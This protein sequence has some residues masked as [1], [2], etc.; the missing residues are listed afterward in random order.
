M[1]LSECHLEILLRQDLSNYDCYETFREIYNKSSRRVVKRQ[2]LQYVKDSIDTLDIPKINPSIITKPTFRYLDGANNRFRGALSVVLGEITEIENPRL[3]GGIVE[4]GWAGILIRDD[5]G[6]Q[7]SI[8]RG[9]PTVHKKEG[10]VVAV[11][12]PDII[13]DFCEQ[14][15]EQIGCSSIRFK[16]AKLKTDFGQIYQNSLKL[17]LSNLSDLVKTYRTK[18]YYSRWCLEDSCR[19]DETLS[20][21]MGLYE[22][23]LVVAG[24]IKD[25]LEDYFSSSGFITQYKDIENGVVT[26]P[27]VALKKTLK[28]ADEEKYR[29]LLEKINNPSKERGP[30]WF[31]TNLK[32]YDI[33]ENCI[34][35]MN[36]KTEEA[37]KLLRR[38]NLPH[39]V[40]QLLLAWGETHRNLYNCPIDITKLSTEL[41]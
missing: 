9:K 7:D 23:D 6:D 4:L 30:E 20:K 18:S 3:F 22:N 14:A 16:E 19:N 17:E 36:E 11:H 35:T 15:L 37:E 31:L 13:F 28:E 10:Y 21:Y 40:K 1:V 5:I 12:I 29:E 27:I 8:R 39:E 33:I 26:W 24:Q 2:F 32:E 34:E 38:M 41:I 25:D